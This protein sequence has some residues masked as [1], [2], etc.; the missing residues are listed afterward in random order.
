MRLDDVER[1]FDRL[2]REESD[3][4]RWRDDDLFPDEDDDFEDDDDDD[5]DDEGTGD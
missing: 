4:Q 5:D 2:F 3:K 1:E